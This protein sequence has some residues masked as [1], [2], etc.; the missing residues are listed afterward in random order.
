LAAWVVDAEQG[1][2]AAHLLHVEVFV[3]EA[4]NRVRFVQ[5]I[6]APII[7]SR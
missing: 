6:G 1:E 3:I 4:E 2:L 7:I 5:R